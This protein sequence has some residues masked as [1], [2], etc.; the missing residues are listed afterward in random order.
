MT[1][2]V[3][4]DLFDF[5]PEPPCN[6][7]AW[8]A[9]LVD[10]VGHCLLCPSTS[11]DVLPLTPPDPTPVILAAVHNDPRASHVA[12]RRVLRVAITECAARHHGQVHIAWFRH[13]LPE[14]IDPHTVGGAVAGWTAAGYLKAIPD[15]WEPNGGGSNAAKPTQVRRLVSPIPPITR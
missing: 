12:A 14:W 7:G 8:V 15:Q 9:P 11:A 5:S 3:Q 6:H 2:A 1:L 13:L 4:P 10:G